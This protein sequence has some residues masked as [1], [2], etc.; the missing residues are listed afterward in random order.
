MTVNHITDRRLDHL[1]IWHNKHLNDLLFRFAEHCNDPPPENNEM[2]LD[3]I[4]CRKD[5]GGV[6]KSYEP[7]AAETISRFAF[8]PLIVRD[9]RAP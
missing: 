6:L 4:V 5:L 7:L 8:F 1:T 2:N 9:R 3:E